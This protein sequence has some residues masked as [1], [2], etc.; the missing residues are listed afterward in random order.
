MTAPMSGQTEPELS[1]PDRARLAQSFDATAAAYELGRPEYPDE[2]LTFW[3]DHGA[4]ERG[5]V[6]LDLAAG[7]GKLTRLL[8]VMCK[9]HA[10][11]P[12]AQMRAEF[13]RAVPDV[14][15]LDGTAEQIPFPDNTFDAVVVGQAFHWFDQQV[16]L[17]E[18]ARVLTPGGGLALIWNEDDIDAAAWLVDV[19]DEKRSTAASTVAGK[20]PVIEMI[21]ANSTFGPVETF[22][23]RWERPTNLE[24]VLAD[25]LSR[26]YVSALPP[27]ER[28]PVLT[29]TREAIERHLGSDVE[30]ISYPYRTT[31]FWT[32]LITPTDPA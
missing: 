14:D 13:A 10:V 8:P 5:N 1:S 17:D 20:H 22:E 23:C 30:A 4:F 11:E 18:I 29:R 21:D 6:I 16:A 15:V 19:V 31:A 12:L 3:D 26:S 2:A 25:V 32:P 24:G 9:L 27:E 7:T 28:L